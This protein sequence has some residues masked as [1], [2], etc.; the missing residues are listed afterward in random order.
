MAGVEDHEVVGAR[1]AIA[2]RCGRLDLT[3]MLLAVLAG[4]VYDVISKIDMK[5]LPEARTPEADCVVELPGR[6]SGL[7]SEMVLS[8]EPP[9]AIA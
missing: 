6:R 9:S 2:T 3:R 8:S 4:E 1:G 5:L 7:V